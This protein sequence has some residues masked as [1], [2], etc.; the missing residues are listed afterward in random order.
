MDTNNFV[1]F[2]GHTGHK[3]DKGEFGKDGEKVNLK[4]RNRAIRGELVSVSA[5]LSF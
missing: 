4:Q 3:G 2:Q 1:C 5:S